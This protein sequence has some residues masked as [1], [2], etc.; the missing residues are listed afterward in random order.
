MRTTA[1][2][3]GLV[4]PASRSESTASPHLVKPPLAHDNSLE[5]QK[6]QGDIANL[7]AFRRT[8]LGEGLEKFVD[9]SQQAREKAALPSGHR[10]HLSQE[11][12]RQ[13]IKDAIE[14]SLNSTLMPVDPGSAYRSERDLE[15]GGSV[16]LMRFIED[17]GWRVPV[18]YDE[19]RN[20]YESLG[21]VAPSTPLHGNFGGALAWPV[22]LSHEDQLSLYYHQIQTLPGVEEDGLF[23]T[24]TR[25]LPLDR[26]TLAQPRRVLERLIGSRA[27]QAVG[28]GLQRKC[29]GVV[30]ASS[31]ADWLLAALHASLDE[32]TLLASA[33]S[34]TR[35]SIAGFDLAKDEHI[36]K[37]PVTVVRA[38]VDHLADQHT[39]SAELASVAAYL[40]LS[41]RAPAFLV[42]DIPAG[43]KCGSHAWVSLQVAVARLE[44]KA[45]GSTA[46]MNYAQV[47]EHAEMAP[48]T[49]EDQAVEYAAQQSALKDWGVANGVIPFNANDQYTASQLSTLHS[50]F[51]VQIQALRAGSEAYASE[52]PTRREL[53]LTHLKQAYGRAVPFEKRCISLYRDSRDH[54]GPY[55]L[56]DLYLHYGN[57]DGVGTSWVSNSADVPLKQ[58]STKDRLPNIEAEFSSA[59]T[60]YCE[61]MDKAI[62][63][64]AAHLIASL[65][66]DDRNHLESGELTIARAISITRGGYG[67]FP[68][69]RTPNDHSLYLKT[70]HQ[71]EVRTYVLNLKDNVIQRQD[72]P[73]WELGELLGGDGQAYGRFEKVADSPA[74]PAREGHPP[75][76][77]SARTALIA[78]AMV[79]DAAIRRHEGEARGRTTFESEVPFYKAGREFLLN[80]IPFRSAII[81]FEQGNIGDGIVDLTFDA[82]GFMLGAGAAARSVK[83]LRA[84]ASL[85]A[86]VARGGKIIGRA[87]V[88]A[89]N[90]LDGTGALLFN[91]A[92]GG[93]KSTL[94]AYRLLRGSADSYN[95][96]EASKHFDASAVGTFKL[97]DAI[98]EGPAV[99]TGGKWYAFDSV[100]GRPYGTA[101]DDFQPSLRSTQAQL[102]NWGSTAPVISDSS[103][104]LRKRWAERVE[105]HKADAPADF[106]RGYNEGDPRAITG[107]RP[108]MKAEDIRR[109]AISAQLTPAEIGSLARQE[110]R[111]AVQHGFKGVS[112]VYEHV[113]A[114]G[115]S[116]I[117]APQVFYLSQTNPL[118]QGQCAAMSRLMAS[119]MEQGTQATFIGN[120]FTA[121]ANPAAQ[122][123]REFVTQLT[124]VQKQLSGPTL[125]HAARPR[126]KMDYKG[127]I[128]EL[129]NAREPR[130]LM[131][132]TPGHAMAAGTMGE[133]SNKKFYFYDPNFGVATFSSPEAMRRGLEKLFSDKKLP[134]QYTTH[135]TDPG[136]LE[137]EVSVY[138]NAWKDTCGVRDKTVKDL[139]EVPLLG[140]STPVIQPA[141]PRTPQIPLQPA[142][143]SPQP[144]EVLMGQSHTLT[145]QTSTLR[146]TSLSDC[147]AVVV[148]SNLKDGV[149][150]K[151]TLVHLTGSNLAQPVNSA[152]DGFAWLKQ[153]NKD[154][155]GG[156]KVLF[157]GG[158]DTKSVVGVA[159]VIGQQGEQSGQP[160]L[161]LLQRKDVSVTYASSAGVEVYPDGTFKLNDNDGAGVFSESK[162]KDIIDFA[163]D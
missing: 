47:M 105:Q 18:T 101:L 82:F 137:F 40:L 43:V 78:S 99:L 19:L 132:A 13:K 113:S 89:L 7:Q 74:G 3:L 117:P 116:F 126:R 100:N 119:A 161:D 133:G 24:L 54:P 23:K 143:A 25:N 85:G 127:I 20:L 8:L 56:L 76:Y 134:V 63:T 29:G 142:A 38:L 62:A 149:Y 72:T 107:F 67:P 35:N 141:G 60:G 97:K 87:A 1:N 61:A 92:R 102:A 46:L 33:P 80:L 123:S 73:Q 83:A 34:S 77:T 103:A 59:F 135:S 71:G 95:L 157:V 122:T 28:E 36:G 51:N 11:D 5:P 136:R 159:V 30:T 10:D 130:S 81:H 152:S 39:L 42:K 151:R 65:P 44:A 50:A 90:P 64:H 57:L 138:D 52:M 144:V 53:A 2:T 55:S 114:A 156:G 32:K 120:L 145:D 148:L 121:A 94:H 4:P 110:E 140:A 75:S 68:E 26:A 27:G 153:V 86:R 139:T 154:L 58:L 17:N 41:R 155:E 162:V 131:L 31:N 112:Q 45:P 96:L 66:L 22:P 150:Q 6:L 49:V 147:S 9:L 84:G 163:K 104:A 118:S 98:V 125:F 158:T 91:L 106:L 21:T 93:Q 70:E 16:S 12:Y 69:R 108:A 109:L 48:I 37:P 79:E 160:L 124:A 146:T 15:P 14:R 111:L 128:A 88:G 129:T 115:G